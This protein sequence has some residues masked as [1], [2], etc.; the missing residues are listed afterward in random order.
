MIFLMLDEG[1]NASRRGLVLDNT[2]DYAV[3]SLVKDY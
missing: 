2:A 1:N 3:H